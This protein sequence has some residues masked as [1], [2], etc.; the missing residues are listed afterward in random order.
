M[1]FG[2]V[3]ETMA[4]SIETITGASADTD[5]NSQSA[6]VPRM[7]YKLLYRINGCDRYLLWYTNSDDR[8][9]TDSSNRILS[10]ENEMKLDAFAQSASIVVQPEA[11][12]LQ[13]LDRVGLWVSNP[14]SAI[15]A[16]D[17]LLS[18]WNLLIDVAR[19]L[20][21]EGS[22]FLKE[23]E[24]EQLSCLYDRLFWGTNPKALTPEN[25]Q[26]RPEWSASELSMLAEHF[27][28]GIDM[29]AGN[30]GDASV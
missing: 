14:G 6:Y 12:I 27:G 11:P 15:L 24:D 18:V 7:Y 13:N 5:F 19:S 8:V 26:F 2:A 30:L 25:L 10:F 21:G 1:Q 22:P 20:G 28:K 23:D 16:P 3:L 4:A 17:E 29:F 9:L